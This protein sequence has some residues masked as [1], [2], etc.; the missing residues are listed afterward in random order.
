MSNVRIKDLATDSALAAGD[1]IIVDSDAEGTRKYDIGSGLAG[2]VNKP[3]GNGTSGQVLKTN[4]DGT[5][6][7]ADESGGG[8]SIDP[9]TSNPAALGT[10]SPGTSNDYARG[11][12]VHPLPAIPSASNATPQALGTAA[13]G[14]SNDYA[15]ADHVHAK[16]T[17]PSAATATPQPLG[18][19]A[20]GSSSKYAKEDHVHA[21]PSASDIGAAPAVTEVTVSTAG[22][23]SQ[24]M[25]AGKIY[26]FTGSLTAL[27]IT[28]NS[29]S[30]IPAQYHFDF[31]SGATAPTVTLPSTVKMPDS[32]TVEAN[33]RY[34]IDILNGY[35]VV[36]SWSV[37]S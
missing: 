14:S 36:Q 29:A 2:K 8:S 3:A 10:A 24:A 4:G 16:P 32:F 15:R 26:H 13:A 30:G 17:I 21:M 22:S 31:T 28:L 35:G 11:D 20:V 6:Q 7:W 19:A 25:D 12:H 37:T 9:Y 1:Y 33:K 23:V 27:T 18:T 34:E 5:T